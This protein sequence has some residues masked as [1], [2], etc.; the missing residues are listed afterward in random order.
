MRAALSVLA[1]ACTLAAT[2][3]MAAPPTDDVM[4][5]KIVGNWGQSPTCADGRLTFK[6]DGTFE[7]K[8]LANADGVAGT[9]AIDQGRLTGKNGD[10]DMPVMLLDFD[11]DALLLDDGGGDAERLDRCQPAP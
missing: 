8:G 11:G 9:Y 6:T 1:L 3:A 5:Q 4:R 7:T 2:A 10:N